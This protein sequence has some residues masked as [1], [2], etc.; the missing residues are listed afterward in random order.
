MAATIEKQLEET[1]AKWQQT[2]Q[3]LDKTKSELH[4][5]RE[6]FERSQ[7]Q[8]DEVLGELE[9]TH[10]ELYQLKEK[11]EQQQSE[12]NGE[13]EQELEETKSKLQETEQLLEESQSQLGETMAVLEEHQSQMEQTMGVLEESQGKLQQKQEELEQVKAE[14]AQKQSGVESELQKEL[15]ETKA[16]LRETEQLLEEYQSQL[17]ETMGILEQYQSQ[18]QQKHQELEQVKQEWEQT[19][20]QLQQTKMELRK[21]KGDYKPESIIKDVVNI[22]QETT[23]E[24]KIELPQKFNQGSLNQHQRIARVAEYCVQTWPGDLIEIGCFEGETTKLLAEV[25][26][27]YNRRLVAVN[28]WEIGIQ[29]PQGGEYEAFLKKIELYQT[30]VDIVRGSSLDEKT[31][32]LIKSRELCFAFVDNLH[33]YD[34]CLSDIKTVSHC[35]GIIAVNDLLLNYEIDSAFNKGAEVTQSRKLYLPICKEGYLL[36]L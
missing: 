12:S 34:D 9:Q 24:E 28:P 33:T 30:N 29:N 16:Q 13:V 31:I 8:L 4:D 23:K 22:L 15:E 20:L 36:K 10:F 32:A 2:Q 25:A 14:L 7:S 27:K 11:G 18:S 17:E 3:E 6:E 5:V 26:Q 21:L 19:K 1:Q 35:Q